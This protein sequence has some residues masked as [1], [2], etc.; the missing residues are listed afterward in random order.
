M[1]NQD[2]RKK[3]LARF[4]K[5]KAEHQG[6]DVTQKFLSYLIEENIESGEGKEKDEIAFDV[7]YNIGVNDLNSYAEDFGCTVTV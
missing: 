1:E 7:A 6:Q 4:P 2:V 5:V 3:F